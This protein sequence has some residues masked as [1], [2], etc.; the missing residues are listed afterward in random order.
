[1]SCSLELFPS[2]VPPAVRPSHPPR[3]LLPRAVVLSYSPKLS[4]QAIVSSGTRRMSI[5]QGGT[6]VR[7]PKRGDAGKYMLTRIQAEMHAI[8][9]LRNRYSSICFYIRFILYL[10][11]HPLS[12]RVK[13]YAEK[14]TH[15]WHILTKGCTRE[16]RI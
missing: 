4:S 6:L 3:L 9:I 13:G 1:M 7:R 15:K 10:I 5:Y 2:A 14:G 11:V 16:G 12:K 8:P